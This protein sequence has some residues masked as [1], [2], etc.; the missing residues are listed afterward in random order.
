MPNFGL[1]VTPTFNPMSYEQYVQPFKDYA[2]VYNKISDSYDA[3]EME[4]GKWEKLANSTT[5]AAQYQQYKRYAEDLRLAAS[6][7]A[8][9]GLSHKTRSTL[10]NLRNRYTKEIQPISDAFDYRVKMMEE[11]RKLNPKGD[12]QWDIDFSKVSLGEIMNNPTLSYSPGRSLSEM[13]KAGFE[14]AKAASSRRTIS[15]KAQDLG[16]QYYRIISGYSN[17]DVNEFLTKNQNSDA[18]RELM[19]LYDQIRTSYGTTDNSK[20]TQE[21][22]YTADERILTGMLKGLVKQEDYQT[23]YWGKPNASSSSR[24]GSGSGDEIEYTPIGYSTIIGGVEYIKTNESGET[25]YYDLN[26]KKY[27]WG[28]TGRVDS[29]GNSIGG[30]VSSDGTELD[31]TKQSAREKQYMEERF[32]VAPVN[33]SGTMVYVVDLWDRDSQGNPRKVTQNG[34]VVTYDRSK[35]TW[36]AVTR[37]VENIPSD[38][39]TKTTV[40]KA[41]T[42]GYV[43][44]SNS[45]GKTSRKQGDFGNIS[46]EELLEVVAQSTPLDYN[47]LSASEISHLPDIVKKAP[48]SY[49][50]YRIE[51]DAKGWGTGDNTMIYYKPTSTTQVEEDFNENE[52]E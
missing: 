5:D 33:N 14:V 51:E 3:L 28:D 40:P 45:K 30:Y 35:Q 29:E 52:I 36:N 42:P 23:N 32:A 25:I 26:G 12:L 8:E 27:V 2:E 10:S 9:N 20:Y 6:D 24:S 47:S 50:F 48:N 41:A 22:N 16:N 13:E 39:K 38:T 15:E 34:Q 43:F 44:V 21:Q 18:F 17:E 7:L 11:Q 31:F 1:V 19:G 4:A 49:I 37:K 46:N